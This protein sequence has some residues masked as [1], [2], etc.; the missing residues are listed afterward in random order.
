[1]NKTFLLFILL[2]LLV[3]VVAFYVFAGG[4]GADLLAPFM[5]GSGQTAAVED[6]SQEPAVEDTG[7][8][9]L[10]MKVWTWVETRQNDEQRITPKDTKLFTL[11]FGDGDT[12]TATTDC[13]AMGGRY[14][15]GDD[16]TITFS[17]IY[18]TKMYCEGSQESEFA[19]L[20]QNAIAYHFTD[21]A[22][23][24]LNLKFDSGSATFK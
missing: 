23:L 12:F 4:K 18:S 6:S 20:L 21:K 2:V 9:S 14:V 8:M 13:N 1:M 5:G 24:I 11:T 16:K 17:D 15:T 19:S 22:E 10:Q 3:V 7:L